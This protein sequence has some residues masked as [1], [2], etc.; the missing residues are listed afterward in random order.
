MAATYTVLLAGPV[1][2]A[3]ST[4]IVQGDVLRLVSVAD[5][6]AASGLLPGQSVQWDVTVSAEASDPGVVRIGASAT[7]DAAL[8]VDVLTCAQEWDETGCSAGASELRSSWSMPR[9]GT[10]TPLVQMTDSEVVHLRL[11]IS[12]ESAETGATQVQ[13]HARGAGD[14][15]VIGPENALAT[16][17]LPPHMPWVL[18]GAIILVGAG[19]AAGARG[20]RRESMGGEKQ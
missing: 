16:T 14:S 9:D 12:L 18:G 15:V 7:G 13:V 3:P 4:H 10:E 17:G 20:R 2:A 8:L 11:V 5:W 19:L 6:E 1:W